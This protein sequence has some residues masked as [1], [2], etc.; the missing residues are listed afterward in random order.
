VRVIADRKVFALFLLIAVLGAILA[1]VA[2]R[3]TGP[4]GIEERFNRAAGLPGTGGAAGS[5]WFGF[6]LEGDPAAYWVLL[7]ALALLSLFTFFRGR[8]HGGG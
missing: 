4:L 1:F 3:M 7:G 5:G 2:Y 6:T 8:R